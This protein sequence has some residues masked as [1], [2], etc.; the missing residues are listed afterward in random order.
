MTSNSKFP[1]RATHVVAAALCAFFLVG[2]NRGD[3]DD[4]FAVAPQIRIDTINGLPPTSYSCPTSPLSNPVV[5]RGSGQ[6]STPPGRVEQYGVQINWGDGSPIQIASS[7]F[8]PPS[9]R[10][11][12]FTYVFETPAHTYPN[13]N[14]T[15]SI[16]LFHT[17]P[18]GN[19]N[20][21]DAT[22]TFQVCT[23][24]PVTPAIQ[25]E[26]LNGQDPSSFS[27]PDN[28]TPS[29]VILSGGGQG[30]APPGNVSNYSVVV[31]WGDGSAS[32]DAVATFTPSSGSGVN[33]TYEF[34][35]LD[36]TYAVSGNYTAT[37]SLVVNTGAG[38]QV[39]VSDTL[40]ICAFTPIAYAIQIDT[41]NDVAPDTIVCPAGAPTNPISVAGSG[42]GSA[43]P[44]NAEDYSVRIDWGD[45]SPAETANATFT[46]PNGTLVNFTF[47]FASTASHSYA[48]SGT[49]TITATLVRSTSTGAVDATSTGEEV[50][51]VLPTGTVTGEVFD[52]LTGFPIFGAIVEDITG[53][54]P[55]LG[56]FPGGSVYV[57]QPTPGSRTIRVRAPGWVDGVAQV[58]VIEDEVTT[59]DFVLDHIASTQDI[60]GAALP[61]GNQGKKLFLIPEC[62]E[63][64]ANGIVVA[65]TCVH[66]GHLFFF[67]DLPN[68]Q[69]TFRGVNAFYQ[70]GSSSVN[71]Q[72]GT[73]TRTERGY[74]LSNIPASVP[75][76]RTRIPVITGGVT[77]VTGN[78]T[79]AVAT[80]VYATFDFE[81]TPV[82]VMN[83][84]TNN[85]VYVID[86]LP[87]GSAQVYA[88]ATDTAARSV[89][90]TPTIVGGQ[91]TT[92]NLTVF[93]FDPETEN[94]VPV[95][96]NPNEIDTDEDTDV[97]LTINQFTVTD[98][99]NVFSTE[100]TLQIYPGFNYTVSNA[101]PNGAQVVLKSNYNGAITVPVTVSDGTTISAPFNLVIGVNAVPDPTV[102]VNF[103]TGSV[104]A[105]GTSSTPLRTVG[106]ALT[107]VE[108]GGEILIGGLS[109]ST[110]PLFTIDKVV[111]LRNDNPG[112]EPVTIN[113]TPVA[114]QAGVTTSRTG[115][116]SGSTSNK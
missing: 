10:G 91:F 114:D 89:V 54:T 73:A 41:I 85:G 86:L 27:C 63:A 11:V 14:F 40:S 87:P 81:G 74:I 37:V 15:L 1:F 19:D 109:T 30:S 71:L 3:V 72:N 2:L 84:T 47:T 52:E 22:A 55:I 44:G 94:F 13:G 24:N 101:V 20:Q 65:T 23:F 38:D 8:T 80:S 4:V 39:V 69:I 57:I 112:G 7:T 16:S 36:H 29:P 12:D 108:P 105:R 60:V 61:I 9:G 110:E 32:E 116:V 106:E 21:I 48:Q 34:D 99:N 115:F 35:S 88:N 50:C 45:G 77:G 82:T 100:H 93:P 78:G 68:G 111:T 64:V 66:A 83:E 33:F 56:S 98:L 28:P 79:T 95:I 102:Y 46:P 25:I 96:T 70:V 26:T 49:Y 43:P 97:Q 18:S 113:P 17:Q 31:D 62:V 6:G 104:G 53:E 107:V 51:V 92:Q 59:L 67:D 76:Q 58:V 5:V 75:E 90:A 103:D 42:Q